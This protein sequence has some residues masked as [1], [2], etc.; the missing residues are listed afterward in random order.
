MAVQHRGCHGLDVFHAACR[1]YAESEGP[2]RL[3]PLTSFAVAEDC[4]TVGLNVGGVLE[5]LDSDYLFG[6]ADSGSDDPGSADP[7]S[8]DPGSDDSDSDGYGSDD[9]IQVSSR[10]M[11]VP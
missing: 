7:G 10:R 6:S 3:P 1:V 2:C 9:P 4:F 8:D 5:A 11:H